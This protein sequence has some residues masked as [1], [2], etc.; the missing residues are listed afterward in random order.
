M[1]NT[2]TTDNDIFNALNSSR[3]TDQIKCEYIALSLW[4]KIPGE[5]IPD[6]TNREFWILND[7][8]GTVKNL[9]TETYQSSSTIGNILREYAPTKML[10]KQK[11]E[12]TDN[13]LH[14]IK[15][16]DESMTAKISR[17]AAWAIMKEIGKRYNTTFQQE[18]FLAPNPNLEQIRA[19]TD[20]ISRITEREK[21][22]T[23]KHQLDGI[24]GHL[25]NKNYDFRKFYI[26]LYTWL[27][28]K[29]DRSI[30]GDLRDFY[31]IPKDKSLT[32]YMNHELLPLYANALEHIVKRYD[33]LRT[34]T[35]D[36]LYTISKKEMIAV[37]RHFSESHDSTK[38]NLSFASIK[39]VIADRK[40]R[41]QTF[42]NEYSRKG[43][44]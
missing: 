21:V 19:H 11:F 8:L 16:T 43:I 35:Y 37:R 32:D 1:Q 26:L 6:Y 23:Y 24:L 10:P 29:D 25:I 15:V 41:E 13:H 17:Y 31:H 2:T 30:K 36:N 22:Q 40:K 3:H 20:E 12:L 5:K 34:Q 14:I 44:R 4:P 38:L 27:F 9:D 42:I 18:Y 33:D 28:P 39:D 7:I